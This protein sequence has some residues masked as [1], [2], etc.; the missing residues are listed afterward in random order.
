MIKAILFKAT[1]LIMVLVMV[2]TICPSHFALYPSLI[3]FQSSEFSEQRSAFYGAKEEL[4]NTYLKNRESMDE[5]YEIGSTKDESFNQLAALS[6][7]VDFSICIDFFDQIR[8]QVNDISEESRR[9]DITLITSKHNAALAML[10]TIKDDEAETSSRKTI[11][12][13]ILYRLN[14]AC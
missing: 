10:N 5:L 7:L 12:G 1:F 2:P 8:K 9:A 3:A 11:A 4:K 6:V 13:N 14:P